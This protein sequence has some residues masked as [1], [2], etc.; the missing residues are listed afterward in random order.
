MVSAWSAS[1]NG[2]QRTEPFCKFLYKKWPK[3]KD[4]SKNLT[5]CLSRA[6]MTSPMFWSMGGGVRPYLDPPLVY[7]LA[8][9]E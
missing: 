6:A 4:L 1:L 2:G 5:L 3:V 8:V 9:T 7:I